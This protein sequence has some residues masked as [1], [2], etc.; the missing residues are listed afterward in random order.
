MERRA[1]QPPRARTVTV[2]ETREKLKLNF[3][4]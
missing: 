1:I 2:P 3:G 4:A